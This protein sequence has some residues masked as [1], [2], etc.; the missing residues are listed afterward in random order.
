MAGQMAHS[1]NIPPMLR[2]VRRVRKSH[3][4]Q[5]GN[6]SPGVSGFAVG[7]GYDGED[8]SGAVAE[9]SRAVSGQRI[10]R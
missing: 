6:F 2:A 7:W 8:P 4:Q 5:T 9:L 10:V 3:L 1:N